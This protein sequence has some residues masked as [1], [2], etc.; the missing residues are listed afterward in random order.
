MVNTAAKTAPETS[1]T[2]STAKPGLGSAI[3]AR[4][5]GV[6]GESSTAT[7]TTT[8]AAATP[9]IAARTIPSASN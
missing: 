6:S 9:M 8:H 1:G 5:T 4:P 7:G 3:L 2:A